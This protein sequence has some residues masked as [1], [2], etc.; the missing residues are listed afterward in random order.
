MKICCVGISTLDRIFTVDALPTEDG[1]YFASNYKEQG[2]GPAATACVACARLGADA[3]MIARVGDDAT[4]K[5]I[6]DEL[7]DEK[8]VVDHMVVINGALSTQASIL[9]D[10]EGSR[11]IVSYPSPSLVKSAKPLEAVDFSAYDLILADVRWHEGTKYAFQKAKE[12]NIPTL[13]DADVTDQDIHDIV[14]LATHCVFSHP[15]LLKFAKK[16]NVDEALKY[17]ATVCPNYVYVTLGSKGVKYLEGSTILD[18]QGFKVDVVDTTGAG[19]VFHGAMA[20][21]VAS[22]Y[23]IVKAIRFASACAALKCT[24]AGGRSGIPTFAEINKFLETH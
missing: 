14:A 20:F 1:K 4:G 7:K 6:I 18:Q 16:D 8:V 13:L 15:G 9:V 24:K 11:V 22:G 2:G 5:A 17:A 21:A 23:K 3:H 12:L 10:K 19:D